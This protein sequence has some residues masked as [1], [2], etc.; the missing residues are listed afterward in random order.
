MPKKLPHFRIFLSSPGDVADERTLARKVIKEELPYDPFLRGRV[1]LEVVSWDDP[2][3]P[4]PMLANMTP[5]E[6]ISRGRPRPSECDIVV[7]IL[8]SRIG[9]PL[10]DTYKK[11]SGEPYLSG[12]EWEYVDALTSSRKPE[13]EILVY[14]RT[15]SPKINLDDSDLFEKRKQFMQVDHFFSLMKGQS[16]SIYRSLSTY[17]SQS[18]FAE[19]LKN[20][21][22]DLLQRRIEHKSIQWKQRARY[23]AKPLWPGS[24][25]PGLR[26]FKAEEASV[27][28]GRGPEVDQMIRFLTNSAHRV[29][30]VV[31]ASGT[32]KSSLIRAGLLPRIEGNAI[33]GSRDWVS[34]AFTPGM[35]GTNPFLALLAQLHSLL[36]GT[37]RSCRGVGGN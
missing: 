2:A 19:R 8:W 27:F 17:S 21:L 5:Q 36:P 31:G 13:P 7:V 24:P 18:E 10:P 32:G 22:K 6:A 4:T 25:Y 28:F 14:R 11:Q 30:A 1:S 35:I 16:R 23:P 33:P 12:T 9:T 37:K 3:A 15:D 34:V 29:L 26:A 20:D